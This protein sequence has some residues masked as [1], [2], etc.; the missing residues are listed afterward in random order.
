MG[1]FLGLVFVLAI[2]VFSTEIY[3]KLG[4]MK[5]EKDDLKDNLKKES[6]KLALEHEREHTKQQRLTLGND[7]EEK[8]MLIGHASIKSDNWRLIE[9]Y[10]D[11]KRLRDVY[12]SLCE[13]G[14]ENELTKQQVSLRKALRD[15]IAVLADEFDFIK[16][17]WRP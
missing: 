8:R 17:K 5:M 2:M 10:E 6:R 11:Y 14:S 4:Y 3:C 9:K 16:Y 12:I 13:L 7:A 15:D 1:E